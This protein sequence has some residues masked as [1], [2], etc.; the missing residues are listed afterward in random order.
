[1]TTLAMMFLHSELVVVVAAVLFTRSG[2][3]RTAEL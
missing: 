2:I 1:M 3:S